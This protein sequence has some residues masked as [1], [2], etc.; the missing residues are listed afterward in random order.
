[1]GEISINASSAFTGPTETETDDLIEQLKKPN[2]PKAK[3]ISII[4]NLVKMIE[5]IQPQ[6]DTSTEMLDKLHKT[7]KKL[8]SSSPP[9]SRISSSPYSR[10]L[11]IIL[12]VAVM[13]A[14]I[15]LVV[16]CS[17]H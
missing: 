1:M 7:K 9:Y 15:T 3:Q 5:S 17:I 16:I 2:L 4:N 11:P 13:V 8:G 14:I 10:M 6:T 12:I